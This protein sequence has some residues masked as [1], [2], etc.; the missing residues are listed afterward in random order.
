MALELMEAVVVAMEAALA[1]A[2]RTLDLHTLRRTTG[3]ASMQ[4]LAWACCICD[5]LSLSKHSMYHWSHT[6]WDADANL[7][8]CRRE[9][10]GAGPAF[11]LSDA[12]CEP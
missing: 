4:K 2:L 3:V 8:Q 12:G 11:D 6:E 7:S 9:S 10:R 1:Q 5:Q